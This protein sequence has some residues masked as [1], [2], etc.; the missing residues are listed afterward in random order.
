MANKFIYNITVERELSDDEIKEI[1]LTDGDLSLLKRN[2]FNKLCSAI[3]T[4]V[5]TRMRE[6]NESLLEEQRSFYESLI[7]FNTLHKIDANNRRIRN[8]RS[9]IETLSKENDDF[10]REVKR[11]LKD[12]LQSYGLSYEAGN[13][14]LPFMF[15]SSRSSADIKRELLNSIT[16]IPRMDWVESELICS[17]D[18]WENLEKEPDRFIEEYFQKAIKLR[19]S[20]NAFFA[21]K[22]K[23]C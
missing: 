18:A 17:K 22:L 8:L 10:L 23:H 16:A 4:Q 3:S 1:T 12:A 20:N 13:L 21:F 14:K 6:Y 5:A 2:T 11:N 7:D 19:E 9:E 15:S